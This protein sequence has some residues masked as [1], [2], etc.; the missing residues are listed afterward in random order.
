MRRASARSRSRCQSHPRRSRARAPWCTPR[1]AWQPATPSRR[2]ALALDEPQLWWTWDTGAQNLYRATVD[3]GAAGVADSVFGVRLLERDSETLAYSLNGQRLFLR[4]VWYPF[5]NIFSS[6]PS[7]RGA[8]ARRRDAARRQQ[9]PHRLVHVRREGRALR[10]LRPARHARVP[11][12]AVPPA[13]A[14]AACSIRPIR[15]SRS[16]GTGRWERSRTSSSSCA[17]TP[18]V[19]LWARVRGDA[20]AG[21]LGVGRL[22]RLQRGD[23][24]DRRAPRSRRDLPPELL[25]L[26]GRAHL[27]RGLSR[28]ASSRTTTSATTTSSPSSARIAPPVVETLREFMPPEVDLGRARKGSRG[29]C[30][31]RSTPRSTP[32][33]G[34]STTRA[35]ARRS[36]ACS[37]TPT[38]PCPRSSASSTRSS[39]TR[40]SACATAPRSIAASAS[41][42]SPAAAPGRTA[43]TCPASS[44]PS[45]TTASGR[46]SATSGSSRPTSRSCSASTT[47]EPLRPRG[48]GSRYRHDLWLVND[49]PHAPSRSRSTCA[50]LDPRGGE[51]ASWSGQRDR[52]R[53]QRAGRSGSSTSSSRRGRRVP[54]AL[55]GA[56]ARRLAGD[57][58]RELGADRAARVR[59]DGARARARPGALQRADP[60]GAAR[61]LGHRA[62]SSST[63]RN[64]HT[65]GL[66]LERGPRGARRRR[67]VRGLGLRR[68]PVPRAR[69]G[70]HRRGRGRRAS[71]SCTRAGRRRST[72]ATAAAPCSTSRR[73]AR[74]CPSACGR[75]TACGTA[76]PPRSARRAARRCSRPTSRACR[77]AASAARPR[78]P[79]PRRTG[80]SG[81]IRC[82]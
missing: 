66:G 47:I 45:S 14:H 7:T 6:A 25:R 29:G 21:A 17:G 46:S 32:T 43:R 12:A 3:A 72:A 30:S 60:R 63:R 59:R 71:A 81:A 15:A 73:S 24:G 70:Q 26:Q 76:R 13:R 78:G 22:H 20:Q 9:Q 80:R 31:C 1:R 65:A 53:R 49:T 55:H 27:E 68:A 52:R 75:T 61:R 18:R 48:A 56:A 5:A 67:L 77:S 50:L 54:G 19:V 79:I 28:S 36:R 82:S 39:G 38:A 23:R 40:P 33:A 16:T 42:T 11:G 37:G 8:L 44:S 69:M 41:P 74:C 34:R 4:G 64:R 57:G 10:R 35:C 51:R 58:E 62:R 2:S